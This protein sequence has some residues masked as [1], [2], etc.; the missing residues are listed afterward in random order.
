M[1]EGHARMSKSFEFCV[2]EVTVLKIVGL[3]AGFFGVPVVVPVTL[4][5]DIAWAAVCPGFLMMVASCRVRLV[6]WA[7]LLTT[8]IG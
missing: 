3:V 4:I 5:A 8:C 7:S 1:S 2:H 6:P